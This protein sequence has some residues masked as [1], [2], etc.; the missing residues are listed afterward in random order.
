[1]ELF[2]FGEHNK[3][4]LGVYSPSSIASKNDVAVL[5]C[6]PF[7]QEY[8]RA[9]MA[10]RQLSNLLNRQGLPTMRFDYFGTGDSYGESN[11]ISLAIWRENTQFAIDELKSMTRCSRIYLAGLRLGAV[12][13]TQVSIQRNDVNRLVLWDP[14]IRGATYLAEIKNGPH[15]QSQQGDWWIHGYPMPPAFRQEISNID[16]SPLDYPENMSVMQ[17]V[18]HDDEQFD[19]FRIKHRD[20]FEY[21]H[22]QSPGDWNYVDHEGSIL[23]PH[24][25][26]RA[27]VTWLSE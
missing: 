17:A 27:I 7:G 24:N 19:T 15:K 12:I 16:L 2:H 8:M 4:L 18:S 5:L 22:V 10:F 25:L 3:K 1:M 20:R 23:L 13:A 26:I 14:I 6:Y 11:E 9:H 21:R